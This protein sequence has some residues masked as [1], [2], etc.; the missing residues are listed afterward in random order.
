LK[1]FE[2]S[3]QP[4]HP[5][6]KVTIMTIPMNGHF[7]NDKT[8]QDLQRRI[9]RRLKYFKSRRDLR[10]EFGFSLPQDNDWTRQTHNRPFLGPPNRSKEFKRIIRYCCGCGFVYYLLEGGGGGGGGAKI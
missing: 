3:K 1:S 10:K 6:R 8:R 7:L 5:E 9:S 2:T 4:K